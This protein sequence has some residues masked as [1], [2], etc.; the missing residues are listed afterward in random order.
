MRKSIFSLIAIAALGVSIVSMQQAQALDAGDTIPICC[1]WNE[2]L[3]KGDGE[4][5]KIQ[6]SYKI[7]GGTEE[8]RA[9]G[10]AAIDA[11]NSA[12]APIVGHPDFLIE[13]TAKGKDGKS[14]LTIKF[15]RG[16]GLIAGQTVR[17]FDKGTDFVRSADINISGKFAGNSNIDQVDEI[18][19]HE[20][21]H[22]L[23][24]GHTDEIDDLMTATVNDIKSIDSCHVAAIS[25]ANSWA[26]DSIGDLDSAIPNAVS[27]Q[28]FVCP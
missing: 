14:D 9:E 11:W 10:Q 4:N 7:S 8:L 21:G 5:K 1:T 2:N 27:P 18:V 6:L 22:A 25:E 12:M 19:R 3:L 15:K 26:F 28:E 16:G 13:N 24:L 17:H 20:I 23:S